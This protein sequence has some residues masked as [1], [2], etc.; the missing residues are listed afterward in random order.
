MSP[1]VLTLE[2]V[3]TIGNA[4]RASATRWLRRVWVDATEPGWT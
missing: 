1:L 4:L 3:M 2:C